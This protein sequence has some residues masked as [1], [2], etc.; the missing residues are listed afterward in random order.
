[1]LLKCLQRGTYWRLLPALLLSEIVTGGF[2]LLKGPRYW[3]V[4][5]HVY[6]SVWLERK[7]TAVAHRMAMLQRRVAQEPVRQMTYRLEF[8]QFA[9]GM[10]AGVAAFVF[11][12]AFRLARLL[13]DGGG[14]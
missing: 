14:S 9:N 3:L 10:L 4:K 6:H 11:H 8:G 1:M 5:P 2:L 12:P 13:L 7:R